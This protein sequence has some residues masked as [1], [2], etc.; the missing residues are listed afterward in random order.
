MKY[1]DIVAG[2]NM[3]LDGEHFSEDQ[4]IKHMD[5]VVDRI[6]EALTS[7]YPTFTEARALPG[8]DGTYTMFPDEYIR[9]VVFVGGA[10]EYYEAEE[11]GEAVARGY[12]A[13]Y[14]QALFEMKRDYL[15][16]V[17]EIFQRTDKGYLDLVGWYTGSLLDATPDNIYPDVASTELTVIKARL[18][19]ALAAIAALEAE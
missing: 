19:E 6:N 10:A 3:K 12:V 11:E 13:K 14:E 7:G 1:K 2:I 4:L 8:F 16:L 9:K 15:M 17:P 5:S 18:N